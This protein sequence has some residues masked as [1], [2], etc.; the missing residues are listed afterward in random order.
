M[1][2]PTITAMANAALDLTDALVR[3]RDETISGR[4]PA[5]LAVAGTRNPP[6]HENDCPVPALAKMALQVL[7]D[8]GA[9]RFIP[10]SRFDTVA[11]VREARGPYWIADLDGIWHT[12]KM[13]LAR[14]GSRRPFR[15]FPESSPQGTPCPDCL[16][17]VTAFDPSPAERAK[18]REWR[19]AALA[20][21]PWPQRDDEA[22]TRHVTGEDYAA[23][24]KPVNVIGWGREVSRYG[25]AHVV[26]PWHAIMAPSLGPACGPMAGRTIA[27]P[28]SPAL[29]KGSTPCPQ[30]TALVTFRPRTLNTGVTRPKAKARKAPKRKAP[31]LHGW[32][33]EVPGRHLPRPW[34][35]MWH[36]VAPAETGKRRRS[37]CVVEAGLSTHKPKD[38]P[39]TDAPRC[40]Y[41]QGIEHRVTK[42]RKRLRR[43]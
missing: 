5:C 3:R 15:G 20:G 37:F 31:I 24:L 25:L 26:P 8:M 36:L 38:A 34:T 21:A 33:P 2:T 30:C 40:T 42:A 35:P 19:R 13:G 10:L 39:P 12:P 43:S 9:E 16:A 41:C 29:P 1:K 32:A 14:C 7:R 28:L 4:C 18:R 11:Q 17:A 6:Q 22:G 23:P 27:V